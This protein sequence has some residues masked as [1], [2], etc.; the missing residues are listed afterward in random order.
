MNYRQF[1]TSSGL[2]VIAGKN[3]SQNDNIVKLAKKGDLILHTETRG[4][5][6][7]IIKSK[8]RGKID[9]QSIKA[10]AIFCASFSKGW[11]E[12][13]RKIT[14][15]AFNPEDT[16]KSKG[17]AIGTYG[18]KKVTMKLTVTPALA[19]GKKNKR[20]QCSP[21]SALDKTYIKISQGKLDKEK[22]SE[23]ILEKLRKKNIKASKEKIMQL[24]PAGGF[25][26][27]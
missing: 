17:M 13:K 5:P 12:G 4:S 10:A 25:S 11:K 1:K 2:N 9:A 22:A 27:K 6:F 14:V 7:C 15:H 19:I 23:K 20:L 3:A 18:V 26:I 24:I 21:E 16:Y 8:S